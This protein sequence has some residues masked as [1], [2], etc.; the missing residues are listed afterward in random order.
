MKMLPTLP[1]M[2]RA[3]SN[4]SLDMRLHSGDSV[5]GENSVVCWEFPEDD[6]LLLAPLTRA[7]VFCSS[8]S[9]NVTAVVEDDSAAD[10]VAL[11]NPEMSSGPPSRSVALVKLCMVHRNAQSL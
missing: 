4:N 9:S 10:D 11:I 5:T 8:N 7:N 6:R 2:Q 3:E 1:K